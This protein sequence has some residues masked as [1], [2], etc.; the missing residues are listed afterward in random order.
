MDL[1][2]FLQMKKIGKNKREYDFTPLGVRSDTPITGEN[3]QMRDN[4]SLNP[5]V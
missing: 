1:K 4:K 3:T 2:Y 5:D